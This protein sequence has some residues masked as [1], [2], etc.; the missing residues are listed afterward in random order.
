M[1]DLLNEVHGSEHFTK[2]DLKA[3]CH[4]M[5]LRDTDRE[6][7]A[8]T[9]K[10]RLFEWIVVLFGL[11]N[12]PSAFMRTMAKVLAKHHKNYVEY[13][14]DILIHSRSTKERHC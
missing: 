7:T 5:R 9:T 4:Q 2:L 12:V 3:G 13:L 1:D 10:Y 6:K 14:D 8:F 11:A